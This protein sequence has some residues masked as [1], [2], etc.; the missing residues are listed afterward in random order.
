MNVFVE[1]C[2][3]SCQDIEAKVWAAVQCNSAFE[4][5]QW[6]AFEVEPILSSELP[7]SIEGEKVVEVVDAAISIAAGYNEGNSD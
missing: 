5:G 1:E 3:E 6:H 7:V 4:D 2:F